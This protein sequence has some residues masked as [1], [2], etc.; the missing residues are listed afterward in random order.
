MSTMCE[1]IKR[2]ISNEKFTLKKVDEFEMMTGENFIGISINF[3]ENTDRIEEVKEKMVATIV[4]DRRCHEEVVSSFMWML[5]E[6]TMLTVFS[7]VEGAADSQ[8]VKTFSKKLRE[9]IRFA[10]WFTFVFAIIGIA[11]YSIGCYVTGS[12]S[13]FEGRGF[14]V[15]IISLILFAV[16]CAGFLKGFG[17]PIFIAIQNLRN[18]FRSF[19]TNVSK[20]EKKA[21]TIKAFAQESIVIGFIVGVVFG[22][23]AEL[24]SRIVSGEFV[25]LPGGVVVFSVPP[26]GIVVFSVF[27]L[28]VLCGILLTRSIRHF[29][30]LTIGFLAGFLSVLLCLGLDVLLVMAS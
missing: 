14:G 24:P 7:V 23:F 17:V 5:D 12:A 20:R 2:D 19:E 8:E 16:M 22:S 11:S 27:F 29:L 30:G 28:V 1:E 6:V 3:D 10:S 21:K 9:G 15:V 26:L 4:Q 18:K 25:F 13:V